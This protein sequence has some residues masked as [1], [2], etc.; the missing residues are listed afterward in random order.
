MWRHRQQPRAGTGAGAGAGGPR[1]GGQGGAAARPSSGTDLAGGRR[2]AA[3][4]VGDALRS[5]PGAV[6]VRARGEAS[7]SSLLL[8]GVAEMARALFPAMKVRGAVP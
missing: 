5:D 1:P 7:P 2:G 4:A 6:A 8:P 3:A